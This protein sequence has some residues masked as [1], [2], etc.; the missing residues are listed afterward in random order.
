VWYG[1][2]W[3]VH[4]SWRG[5]ALMHHSDRSDKDEIRVAVVKAQSRFI[6]TERGVGY[7]FSAPAEILLSVCTDHSLRE[8]T[9]AS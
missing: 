8:R 6:I 2:P 9:H 1:V 5:D 4:G 7:S 3:S